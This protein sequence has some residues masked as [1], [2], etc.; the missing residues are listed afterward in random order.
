LDFD[1]IKGQNWS[2]EWALPLINSSLDLNDLIKDTTGIINEDEDGL[3]TLVYESEDFF[4]LDIQEL[5]GISDQESDV[6]VNF[7]LPQIPPDFSGEF[8]LVF[9]LPFELDQDGQRID[10]ALIKTGTYHL[11]VRTDL[12]KDDANA[13]FTIPNMISSETNDPLQFNININYQPSQNEVFK[14]TIIDLAGYTMTLDQTSSGS[15]EIYIHSVVSF[16]GDNNPDHSPYFMELENDFSGF[17]FYNFFGYAGSQTFE[18]VDSLNLNIFNINEDG[19]FSFGPGSVNL[20]IDLYNSFG[21]P[22]DLEFTK[23]RAYHGG[24][25]PDSLDVYLFGEGNPS[26][27]ELNYPDISEVGQVAITEVETVNSNIHEALN[28][29]PDKILIELEG[30]VNPEDNPDEENFILDTSFLKA[31]ISLQLELFGS[32]NGFSVADTVDFEINNVDEIDYIEFAVDISNGFPIGAEVQLY[33]VDSV[34]NQLH[35]LLP[36]DEM[37]MVAASVGSAPDYKVLSPADKL[38]YISLNKEELELIT[39]AQEIIINATF[40]TQEGELVKIYSD[41]NIDF[42]MGAKFGLSIF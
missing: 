5:T 12:N 4:E 32:V 29:S 30:H 18:T 39:Y 42:K 37:L 23:F 7:D 9:A 3:I 8:P 40:S 11:K 41:Y 25:N 38:T 22:A 19:Y 35:A 14:D 6:E 16:N 33:F 1:N 17:E 13:F 24:S 36:P 21:I 10:S 28:I 27:I 34:Y 15:N 20:I 2:S 31:D 26:I